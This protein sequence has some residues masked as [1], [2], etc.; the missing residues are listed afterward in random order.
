MSVFGIILISIITILHVYV[1][2][3]AAAIPLIRHHMPLG[4]LVILGI[5]L[6]GLFFLSLALRH[7][8]AGPLAGLLEFAGMGWMGML[9]LIFVTLLAVDLVT[10]FGFLLPRQAPYLRG[11]A[12][13][14]GM[15]LSILAFFQA[16]R[17]PLVKDYSVA[18]RDLPDQMAGK[19]IVAMT[20][21]HLGTQ[22]GQQWLAARV[23]QVQALDPDMVVLVGDILDGHDG[24]LTDLVD[25]LRRLEAPLG[26]Y[27]VL[28]N[29]EFY[30]D[31]ELCTRVLKSA[32][33]EVL[34]NRW[35]EVHP[36]LILAGV[37]DLTVNSRIKPEKDLVAQALASRPPGAVILLSHTPWQ[38]RKAALSGVG[39]MLSGHTHNGQL[40]PFNYLVR[41]VYPL[42]YGSHRIDKMTAIVSRG[43]G[44]WGPR[45]RLWHP[46]EI[47]SIRLKRGPII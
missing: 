33:I 10:L 4:Y 42:I 5:G 46:G 3:R 25:E 1:F 12:L 24:V 44:T 34:R 2:G 7:G 18:V 19:K 40:W 11:L 37:D 35:M 32:G 30:R 27:A 45:M 28:G 29:H 31:A 26:V 16:F 38:A 47:L 9:F 8:Q 39:L 6:W 17:P 14:I 13:A 22:L 20:D 23:D 41:R 36:G 21:M 43:A 15:A